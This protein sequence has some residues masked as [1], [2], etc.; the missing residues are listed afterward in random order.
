MFYLDFK[1]I[2]GGEDWKRNSC[3]EE[4]STR[5]ELTEGLDVRVFYNLKSK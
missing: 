4:P 2:F 3:V 1:C 5:G